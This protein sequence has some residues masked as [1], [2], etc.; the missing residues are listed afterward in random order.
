MFYHVM[1]ACYQ[2]GN[3]NAL[4]RPTLYTHLSLFLF[5]VGLCSRRIYP[6]QVTWSHGGHWMRSRCI[7]RVDME[8]TRSIIQTCAR[9]GYLSEAIDGIWGETWLHQRSGFT[10]ASMMIHGFIGQSRSITISAHQKTTPALISTGDGDRTAATNRGS[11]SWPAIAAR[12]WPDC[13]AIV[14]NSPRD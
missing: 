8:S 6:L 3:A 4:L 14:A 12:S 5:R 7:H 1:I 9:N 2:G 13:R 10:K 11:W